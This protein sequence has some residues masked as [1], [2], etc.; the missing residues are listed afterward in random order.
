[1]TP[2]RILN[3]CAEF[4]PLAKSG[5]LGDVTA[6]LARHLTA[7]GQDVVTV[8][9]RYGIIAAPPAGAEPVAGPNSLTVGGANIEYCIFLHDIGPEVGR[10]FVV[11]CP[12]LF[13]DE[14]YSSGEP[15]AHRFVLLCRAALD[16][17]R[18]L[19]WSPEIVHCHDWH[20][21]LV[22]A[23][24]REAARSEPLFTAASTVLTIHNIGYQG[25]FSANVLRDTGYEDLLE[26]TDPVDLAADDVNMLKTG[27]MHADALT[28]VSPTHAGE[29]QTPEYGMG[30][31]ILLQQRGHRLL[32]I[33]NGVDYALWSPETDPHIDVRYSAETIADKRRNKLAL[34]EELA[35]DADV[36]AP[37]LGMVSRLVLQKGVDLFEAVLPEML[38]EQGA[39]CVVLGTGE[40]PYTDAMR[41]LADEWPDRLAFIEAYDDRMSH[42]ILAGSDLFVI[43]SRY[44]PCGLTQLYA[45]RYGTVPVV[46]KTGGLADSIRHFDPATGE[47]NGSVFEDANADGL[48]WGLTAALDWYRD[49]DAWSRLMANGMSADFSWHHQAPAYEKL[50]RTLAGK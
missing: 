12:E 22:P 10:V 49:P 36:D 16:L 39:R 18:A 9:P 33:L 14:I 11:D 45:L 34:L 38:G 44:E 4:V 41:A 31:E 50:Y 6:A 19:E 27:V 25:V 15:E 30:L 37:V 32:G 3:V 1:M 24:L 48:R 2:L 35:L 46:R 21:A 43:P 20:T 13:G 7:T 5:G 23:L 40:P 47:G 29:I 28:T 17:C 26:L 42:R 8:L